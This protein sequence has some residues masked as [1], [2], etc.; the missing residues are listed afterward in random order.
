MSATR[1]LLTTA[2]AADPD[3]RNPFTTILFYPAV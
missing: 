3:Q 2:T 1:I